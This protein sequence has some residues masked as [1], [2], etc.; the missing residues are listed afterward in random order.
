MIK[1]L[2]GNVIRAPDKGEDLTELLFKQT[3]ASL[4]TLG[5]TSW[6]NGRAGESEDA[7]GGFQVGWKG[8]LAVGV[9]P[10]RVAEV[11]RPIQEAQMGTILQFSTTRDPLTLGFLIQ[12]KCGGH[13]INCLVDTGASNV[14]SDGMEEHAVILDAVISARWNQSE[15]HRW[16][17]HRGAGCHQL[18]IV[19]HYMHSD[20]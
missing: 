11:D 1:K 2:S 7:W 4:E 9:S 19:C 6:Q 13:P 10:T 17:P 20:G 8:R 12:R 3:L 5:M 14:I 16:P 15:L 18:A